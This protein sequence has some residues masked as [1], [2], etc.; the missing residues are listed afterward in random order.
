MT[1][2]YVE[3]KYFSTVD[4]SSVGKIEMLSRYYS[5]TPAILIAGGFWITTYGYTV[6]T[7]RRKAINQA[8]EDGEKHIMERYGLPNL[9]AQGTSKNVKE[10]NSVQRS[11]QQCFEHYT[12]IVL[13]GMVGAICYPCTTAISTFLYFVGRYK[14]TTGYGTGNPKNRY[15]S[16]LVF[17]MY[18]GLAMNHA[19]GLLSSVNWCFGK[20]LL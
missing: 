3:T 12:Q 5:L 7:A 9:Y 4:F 8:K 10:F 16:R 1:C 11:Y 14:F 15:S 17:F 2:C 20:V 19:I 13:T 6:G 18:Y